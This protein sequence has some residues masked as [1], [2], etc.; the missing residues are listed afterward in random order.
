MRRPRAEKRSG[1]RPLGLP[2]ATRILGAVS[3]G[4][5]MNTP[6][7]TSGRIRLAVSRRRALVRSGGCLVLLLLVFASFSAV[8]EPFDADFFADELQRAERLN[9]E[10][11]W[12]ESQAVLD[13]LRPDLDRA[14]PD[15]RTSF[16][17]LESR[18]LALDGQIDES[19]AVLDRLLE[20]ELTPAQRLAAHARA[21]NVGYIGRR[22]ETTF[23]HLND[24][25]ERIG[26]PEA[27]PGVS[28]IYSIAAYVYSLVEEFD[29]AEEFGRQAVDIARRAGLTRE[30]CAAHDRLAFAYKRSGNFEGAQRNYLAAL[31]ACPYEEEP[32]V[33]GAIDYGLAD[34]LQNEGRF[35]QAGPRFDRAIE[36]MKEMG[37]RNGLAEARVFRARMAMVQGND[38]LAER[39][40][41]AALPD[42][43]AAGHDEFIAEAH[44]RLAELD[45]KRNELAAA[46][47]HLETSMQSREAHLDAVRARQAA[48][49]RARF[50]DGARER[51]LVR[52]REQ[53]RIAELEARSQV[54]QSQLR[55]VVGAAALLLLLTL[56]VLLFR[57]V[58]DRRR[59]RRLAQRDALTALSNHTR[60]FELAD[61]TLQLAR[62][63]RQAY[64]LVLGDIDH[65]KKVN[66]RH[67]HLVGDR[68]LRRV[69]EL[70]R[71]NLGNIGILGRVGGEEF[72]MALPGV[73]REQARRR[74]EQLQRE[75]VNV[76]DDEMRVP[77]TMSF[78]VASPRDGESLTDLRKRADQR[79]YAA[80]QA[81]RDR[82][83]DEDR[84]E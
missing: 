48:F 52:L 31:E 68:V 23:R 67:G 15:Q 19:L 78:G 36:T 2:R 83:V 82:I 8:S 21:A 4:N 24:A 38:A 18:N 45:R 60:F 54:Q 59:F 34:L 62:E 75:L 29:D 49:L 61:R 32:L 37:Y 80:K 72:G 76:R 5:P 27:S 66:D 84:S 53:Q 11:P 43:V 28:Q 57:A 51:E 35:E 79:L 12:P 41:E 39:L 81:G 22:F 42:L 30:L 17:M 73:E 7:Q 33:A 63:K 65:F 1:R 26:T 56:A 77:I 47:D 14:T 10:A 44:R 20:R 58:R 6:W 64:T 71:N 55:R 50:A 25:F 3:Q 70:L 46:F 69:A 16:R 74:L 40:L 9:I 13:T